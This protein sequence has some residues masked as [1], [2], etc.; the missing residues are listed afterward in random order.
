[1]AK[2]TR[3]RRSRTR[4]L[5]LYLVFVLL[6]NVG[7]ARA[8]GVSTVDPVDQPENFSAVLYDNTNGLPTSEANAIVQTSEG[9]IWIGSYGGLIR[10][11]GDTFVRLDST[12][13]ITSIQC[14]Y[15]DS[16]DRLWIGTN[17]N[18]VAV[19]ERGELRK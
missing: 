9:F 1:M 6:L 15:V 8:D 18:G 19:L 17:D 2:N 5:Y 13:G 12:S 4:C 14:L 11:D 3:N 7:A 16:R 10:Y